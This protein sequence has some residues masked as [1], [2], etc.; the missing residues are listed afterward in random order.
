MSA[1]NPLAAT[2]LT[3]LI[4]AAPAASAEV[5]PRVFVPRQPGTESPWLQSQLRE[6]DNHYAA[7]TQEMQ[8]Q[9]HQAI[10]TMKQQPTAEQLNALR[11]AIGRLESQVKQLGTTTTR[12]EDGLNGFKNQLDTLQSAAKP[13]PASANTADAEYEQA[14]TAL[15]TGDGDI[16]PMRRWTEQHRTDLKAPD[17]YLQLGLHLLVRNHSLGE[18]YLRR[19]AN[20]YPTS[21]QAAQAKIL[22]AGPAPAKAKSAK[23]PTKVAIHKTAAPAPPPVPDVSPANDE[24]ATPASV[25]ASPKPNQA[26]STKRPVKAPENTSDKKTDKSQEKDPDEIETIHIKPPTALQK[27]KRSSAAT[28]FSAPAEAAT[29]PF[30]IPAEAADAAFEQALTALRTGSGNITPMRLWTEQHRTHPKAPEGYLQ[31]ATQLLPRN[32]VLAQLYLK[33]VIN[34]YPKSSQAI[35]AQRLLGA[36]TPTKTAPATQPLSIPEDKRAGS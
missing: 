1:S 8:Q 32:A 20:D 13:A 16:E 17:G 31:M 21:P 12:M 7:Q 10:E 30:S 14:M 9:L 33:R 34:N 29:T 3:L 36:A 25:H 23:P 28:P 24:P 6:I 27:G 18:Q 22:L 15:R 26:D 19:V 2:L 5:Q 4:A 35:Q 11:D